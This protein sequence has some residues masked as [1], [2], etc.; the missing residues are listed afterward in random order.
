MVDQPFL[1]QR[2]KQR[3]RL[4]EHL[5]RGVKEMDG[6]DVRLDLDRSRCADNAD[7]FGLRGLDS[8]TRPWDNYSDDGQARAL[9]DHVKGHR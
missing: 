2:D 6:V 7:A 3:A 5:D 1:N 8:S 4:A 9:L